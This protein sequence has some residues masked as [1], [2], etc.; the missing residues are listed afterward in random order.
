MLTRSVIPFI[1]GFALGG[2][3]FD[4]YKAGPRAIHSPAKQVRHSSGLGVGP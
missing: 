3:V 1:L 2:Y 4:T